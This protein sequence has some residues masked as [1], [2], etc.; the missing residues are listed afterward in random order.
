MPISAQTVDSDVTAT[1]PFDLGAEGQTATIT[2]EDGGEWFNSNYVLLGSNFTYNGTE[3]PKGDG[4]LTQT[5]IQ[6]KGKDSG[7]T[8]NNAIEFM[9]SPKS[10]LTFTPTKVSFVS[11]KWGTGGGIYDIFW[12]NSDGT[13][14]ELATGEKPARENGKD[15]TGQVSRKFEYNVTNASASNGAC[16]LRINVYSLDGP[17]NEG[18][19]AK[20]VGFANIVIEGKVEG[21]IQQVDR[22]NLTIQVS[23]EGAGTVSVQP[24]GSMTFDENTELTLT[25]IGMG[26][27]CAS[28][29]S[30]EGSVGAKGINHDN[31]LMCIEVQF[32]H[33]MT[34]YSKRKKNVDQERTDLLIYGSQVISEPLSASLLTSHHR[35]DPVDQLTHV[36][37][38]DLLVTPIHQPVCSL[39]LVV[40]YM[41]R[42]LNYSLIHPSLHREIIECLSIP[43]CDETFLNTIS[44][45]NIHVG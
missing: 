44:S 34:C 16:G 5:K 25:D 43:P 1:W 31:L 3:T 10:G 45:W 17:N 23:P 18:K 33:S 39:T 26:D 20:N 42:E 15:P 30:R 9:L 13:K 35:L 32:R 29:H 11:T 4:E 22:Y 8:E 6:S 40:W 24:A 12:I 28:I 21:T 19:N 41:E 38:W 36:C 7:P 14:V 2:P 27:Q 37:G